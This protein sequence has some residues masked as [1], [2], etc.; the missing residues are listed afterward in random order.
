MSDP[1]SARATAWCHGGPP[2]SKKPFGYANCAVVAVEERAG[3]GEH[4]ELHRGG[5]RFAPSGS[6]MHAMRHALW[7]VGALVLGGGNVGCEQ[8]AQPTGQ[9]ATSTAPAKPKLP[10][11]GKCAENSDCDTGLGCA[12]DGTCQTF[13]TI[14]CR[15]RDQACAF[16]G[17]CSG[18]DKGCVAATRDDCKKSKVCEN[19]GRCTPDEGKCVAKTSEDC[20]KLCKAEGRCSVEDGKCRA[21]SNDDCKQ[22][23][24]CQQFDQCR[25]RDGLCVKKL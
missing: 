5:L 7:W 12:K 23:E 1:V 10:L 3:V 14:E 24:A 21:T 25:A 9:T 6:K 13:K 19:D 15:G 16:E 18:S 22:S 20:Q 4:A 11:G 8:K 17:R 2:K